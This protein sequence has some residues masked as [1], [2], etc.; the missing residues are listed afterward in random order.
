MS[1][2]FH[3]RLLELSKVKQVVK[4]VEKCADWTIEILIVGLSLFCEAWIPNRSSKKKE[5][6]ERE[7]MEYL[8]DWESHTLFQY[9]R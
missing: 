2:F 3:E 9:T 8:V 5:K 4:R 7:Q 6:K 1:F